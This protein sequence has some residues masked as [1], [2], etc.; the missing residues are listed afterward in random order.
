TGAPPTAGFT[1]SD[2]VVCPLQ[3]I[4][5]TST[6]VVPTG[7]TATY[8][9]NFGN[10]STSTSQNPTHAYGGQGTYTV[11]LEVNVNGCKSVYTKVIVVHPPKASFTVAYNCQNKKQVSFT[12]TSTGGNVFS[13][14][15]GDG[16][17]S[18]AQNP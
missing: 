2:K 1:A 7:A 15:F 10:G 11:T 17:S 13:W 12:N 14:D 16:T 5:F 8:K 6:S 4:A 3:L 18:A 9:W